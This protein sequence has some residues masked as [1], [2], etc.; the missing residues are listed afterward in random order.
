LGF[1]V[2]RK[3]DRFKYSDVQ[4]ASGQI[5]PRLDRSLIGNCRT[6][7]FGHK[8]SVNAERRMAGDRL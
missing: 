4:E 3:R 6:S 8:E 2:W 7:C 1:G 5:A